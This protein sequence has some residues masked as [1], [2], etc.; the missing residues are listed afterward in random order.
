MKLGIVVWRFLI[1]VLAIA[2]QL[3]P[4]QAQQ[5]AGIGVVVTPLTLNGLTTYQYQVVNNSPQRIVALAIGNDYRYGVAE[6]TVY[7]QGWAADTGIVPGS[8]LSAPR[9]S[10]L[11]LTTE[12]TAAVEIRWRNDGGAD[13]LP[14]QTLSGFAV[15]VNGQSVQYTTAHWTAIL[16]NGSVAYGALT[17]VGQ[18]R[19][20]IVLAG[21]TSVSPG[22]FNALIELTNSGGV[23]AT[24]VAITNLVPRSLSGSGTVS[25]IDVTLPIQVG[26]IGA[27][28][29]KTINVVLSVPATVRRIS[30]THQGALKDSN[31]TALNFSAAVSAFVK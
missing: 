5:G 3:T 2:A 10:P 27:G 21:L 12:E 14:G 31:G 26:T 28:A 8:I 1:A 16:G 30:L 9:W 18:P 6:L 19:L 13:I 11:V 20:T 15:G 29:T 22:R 17:Q 4:A 25:L 24:D 23:A 7:P